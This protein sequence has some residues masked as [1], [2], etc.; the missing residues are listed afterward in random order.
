MIGKD[1]AGINRTTMVFMNIH[2]GD[3]DYYEEESREGAEGISIAS[4]SG[5]DFHKPHGD[6]V[7]HQTGSVMYVEFLH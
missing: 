4:R 2:H 7:P 1:A 6:C 5:A 3:D